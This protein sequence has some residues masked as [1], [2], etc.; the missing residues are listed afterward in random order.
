MIG[1]ICMSLA[2]GEELVQL[3]QG[4]YERTRTEQEVDK[5]RKKV[6]IDEIYNFCTPLVSS[7]LDFLPNFRVVVKN[8]LKTSAKV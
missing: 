5:H 7:D 2:Q 3:A 4:Y 6:V 1:L 8:L